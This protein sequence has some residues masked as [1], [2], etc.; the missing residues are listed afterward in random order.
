MSGLGPT[1]TGQPTATSIPT[2]NND[3]SQFQGFDTSQQANNAAAGIGADTA[4]QQAQAQ[5]RASAMGAGRSAGTARTQQDIGAQG[6]QNL[7]NFRANAAQQSFQDQMKQLLANNQFQLGAFQ[8]ANQKYGNEAAEHET[9]I[10]QRQK[11][12]NPF[13]GSL[14]SMFGLG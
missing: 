3:L 5:A 9:E 12:L 10:A 13:I 2:Y 14:G 1:R 7:G 11:A 6:A 4:V 8:G